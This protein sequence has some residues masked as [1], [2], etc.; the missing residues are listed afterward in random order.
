MVGYF[1]LAAE[2]AA[3]GFLAY[4]FGRIWIAASQP[5]YE[6]LSLAPDRPEE[7]LQSQMDM[8][9]AEWKQQAGEVMGRFGY[10]AIW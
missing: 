1:L 10:E 6:A 2:L 7:E 8:L 4:R 5:V 9:I 3:L